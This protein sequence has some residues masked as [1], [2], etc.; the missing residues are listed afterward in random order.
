MRRRLGL[1][2]RVVVLTTS[3]AVVLFSVLG[4]IGF[5]LMADSLRSSVEA[6]VH[7]RIEIVA[8]RLADGASVSRQI[9][10]DGSEVVVVPPGT[11][12]DTREHTLQIVAASSAGGEPVLLVGRI[13]VERVDDNLAAIRRG[14]WIAVA[15]SALLVGGLTWL[16]AGRALA[17]VAAVIDRVQSIY[18]AR[19]AELLPV[20]DTDDEVTD[21]IQTLNEMLERLS[22]HE[23]RHRQ[24]VSDASHELRTPLMVL[25]ADA[26]Y[27]ANHSDDL[28]ALPQQV[29]DQ[30]T[31]LRGLTDELLT[32]ATLDERVALPTAKLGDILDAECTNRETL[33]IEDTVERTTV[34]DVSRALRNL[35]SNAHRHGESVTVTAAATDDHIRIDV[36][37]DGPGV[38]PEDRSRIFGR[39]QRG[40]ESRS[41]EQG[42]SGIGLAIVHAEVTTAGGSVTVSTSPS[43]GAR[44]TIEIPVLSSTRTDD[45]RSSPS[46]SV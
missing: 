21:L 1:R 27:A 17:P 12:V 13:D 35:L 3:T 24:F 20:P 2:G 31:R 25:L 9:W 30:T 10:A 42:G 26:E 5:L 18:R 22:D 41:R 40:D 44:F 8:Q 16:A 38:A 29:I 15:A 28:P 6:T 33:V 45:V 36:D 7:D 19:S 46:H 39:F 43:G 23:E 34:S 11:S 32:L 37:D 4:T 14:L